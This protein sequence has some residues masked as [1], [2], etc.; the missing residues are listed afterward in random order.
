MGCG[1]GSEGVHRREK[2]EPAY[3]VSL[4]LGQRVKSGHPISSAIDLGT[5][6]K[7]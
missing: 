3:S 1:C 5:D 2:T 6:L 7:N 4:D